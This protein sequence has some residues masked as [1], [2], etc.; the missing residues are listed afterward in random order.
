MEANFDGGKQDIKFRDI[1]VHPMGE[2]WAHTT[3]FLTGANG[4]QIK[5]VSPT[6]VSL[7]SIRI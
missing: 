3:A 7:V 6:V 1:N 5:F 4:T 2:D